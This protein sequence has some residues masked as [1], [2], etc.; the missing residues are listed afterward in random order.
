MKRKVCI[1]AVH[2][3]HQF[4][5]IRR[6]YIQNVKDLISIHAVDLVA[7]ESSDRVT[8]FVQELI[9][10][11]AFPGVSWRNVDPGP[12]ERKNWPDVNPN[13]WGTL[14]D[15]EFN[16]SRERV[17]VERTAEAMTTSALLICGYCHLF[18]VAGKF[19]LAEF[20][21]ETHAYFDKADVPKSIPQ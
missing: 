12:D 4:A 9:S 13:G 10:K 3:D 17:W 18:S 8:T 5:V 16:M 15:F 6:A 7:E 14:V 1:L 2:H 19:K 11:G 21:V 20:E